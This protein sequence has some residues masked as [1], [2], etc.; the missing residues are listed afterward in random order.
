MAN[1]SVQRYGCRTPGKGHGRQEDAMERSKN[2]EQ[3]FLLGSTDRFGIYQL[4]DGPG[5]E[6]FRFESTASLIERGVTDESLDAIRPENYELVHVGELSSLEGETR[7]EKLDEIYVG[8]NVFLPEGYKGHSLS[9]SDI[10]VLHENSES[11]AYYVEPYG[12][13]EVPGYVQ[14]VLAQ[15]SGGNGQEALRFG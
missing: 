6:L 2:E 12:F 5:R 7:Q 13:T 11:R 8:F 9:V 1:N 14:N 4:K 3:Q 10:V 15:L